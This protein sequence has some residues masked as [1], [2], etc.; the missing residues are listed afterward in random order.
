MPTVT[1]VLGL[2]GSGKSHIM[3]QMMYL[4]VLDESF[5][6]RKDELFTALRSGKDCAVSEI[7]LCF[8]DKR[9]EILAELAV[10]V[11]G[12]KVNWLCIENDE[13]KASKNCHGRKKPNPAGHASINAEVTKNYTYPEGAIILKMWPPDEEPSEEPSTQS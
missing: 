3:D 6:A 12:V 7:Q 9:A 2:C 13:R 5:Y 4:K 8:A 1:F 11:P 10:V